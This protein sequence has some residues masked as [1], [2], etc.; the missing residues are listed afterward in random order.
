MDADITTILVQW[1]TGDETAL[2]R[3]TPLVYDELLRM[4]K[5]RI[6]GES[7]DVTMQPTTLVH[8]A[9]LKLIGH[10]HLPWQNRAHFFAIA[11]TVMR[12]ILI[13]DARKR[14]AEKRGGGLKIT[15]HE[16][17]D[18]ADEKPA[19]VMALDLALQ[20]LAKIDERKSRIIE[21]KYFGG[22]TTEE[23]SEVMGIS[24]ATVGRELRVGQ[25]ISIAQAQLRQFR[26][27]VNRAPSFWREVSYRGRTQS[28]LCFM[29]SSFMRTPD[30]ATE[31]YS[32]TLTSH[33]KDCGVRQIL[34]LASTSQRG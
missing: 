4:A 8:E 26:F 32:E 1:K 5:L 9:Y 18:V 24:V 7:R 11:A 19:D 31:P 16:E 28:S 2:D 33:S 21:L 15:L 17:M 20:S 12:R 13:D 6:G 30:K 14:K 29:R 3:L 27:L 23:I 25:A 10:T 34:L 22:M